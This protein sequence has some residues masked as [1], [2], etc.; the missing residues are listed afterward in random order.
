LLIKESLMKRF[1]ILFFLSLSV[2]CWCKAQ[3]DAIVAYLDNKLPAIVPLDNYTMAVF[4]L[5]ATPGQMETIKG[6]ADQNT[7]KY[8][9]KIETVAGQKYAYNCTLVFL[10]AENIFDLHKTL[11]FF[12]VTFFEFE[13][14][15]Y[16]INQFTTVFK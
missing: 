16:E 13:G 2:S 5:K 3:D 11:L 15:Q 8:T 6:K 9:L 4:G 1:L 14:K 7:M 10:H 12:G